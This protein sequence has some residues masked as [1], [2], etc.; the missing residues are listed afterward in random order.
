MISGI[1]IIQNTVNGKLYIGRTCNWNKRRKQHIWDLKRGN[2]CNSKLQN[3][4]NKYSD[5]AFCFEL[6]WEESSEN[7][8]ELEQML[9]DEFFVSGKL[10]NLHK[11]SLG[12]M[13]GMKVSDE[14]K[15]KQKVSRENSIKVKKHIE[16]LTSKENLE[17]ATLAAK[18]PES[19]KKA[20]ESRRRNGKKFFNDEFR[21]KQKE[22]T[23]AK[24][25]QALDWAK[26]NKESRQA[27]LT[28]FQCGWGSLKLYLP[29]W[30]DL[31]GKLPDLRLIKKD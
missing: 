31:N 17:K 22:Q 23:R 3:A 24:V 29:D 27:A 30:E 13:L 21:I 10:Y 16:F 4:W 2:H 14:T 8:P 28:K 5:K 7:L 18:S 25:F 11:N 6:I 19:R 20:I 1:Y 15:M 9:L 12:G 26:N